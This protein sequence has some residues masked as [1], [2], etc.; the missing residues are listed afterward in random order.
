MSDIQ[1][2]N[3]QT[4]DTYMKDSKMY[5]TPKL[6]VMLTDQDHTVWNAADIFEQ[7]K[8]SKAEYYGMKEKPLPIEQM[9][10][11]YEQMRA[12]GKKTAMEVVAYTEEEGLKGAALAAE[13]NCDLLMGT[14][15]YDSILGFC[16]DHHMKYMP[17]VGTVT[18]RPSVLSGSIE[19]MILQGE[20]LLHNGVYGINLLGYRYTGNAALLNKQIVS[21]LPAPVCIAGSVDSYHKLDEIRSIHAWAFTIGSAFFEHKFG[22][23]FEEQINRV[24]DYMDNQEAVINSCGIRE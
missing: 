17:Y 15:Y 7:C 24:C 14:L 2:K 12:I 18:E 3:T 10:E 6:I 19:D 1:T 21:R 13:C 11:I 22:G 23:S 5:D 9:K 4:K 20:H 16:R 8:N